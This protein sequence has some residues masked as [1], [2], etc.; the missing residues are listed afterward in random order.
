[1]FKKMF[2]NLFLG[3]H[4]DPATNLA[5]VSVLAG[6]NAIAAFAGLLVFSPVTLFSLGITIYLMMRMRQEYEKLEAT[7]E[8][9]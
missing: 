8:D 9:K 7:E 2:K 1:M 5:V 6:M 4:R 3:Q